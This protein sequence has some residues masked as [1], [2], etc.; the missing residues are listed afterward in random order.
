MDKTNISQEENGGKNALYGQRDTLTGFLCRDAMETEVDRLLAGKRPGLLLIMDID[1]FQ[2]INEEY[3]HMAGD[4]F[5]RKLPE[6]MGYYFFKKD[7]IGRIGG[8]E[9]SVFISGTEKKDFLYGKMGGM[10]ARIKQAAQKMGLEYLE[11]TIGAAVTENRD[12]F[13][14]LCKRASL[15]MRSGKAGQRKEVNFYHGALEHNDNE[16]EMGCLKAERFDDL[17]YVCRQLEGINS[18]G[19]D[20][21]QDYLNFLAVC[22]FLKNR[23]FRT[24]F[25]AQLVLISLSEQHGC[26]IGLRERDFLAD[27]LKKSIRC[28]LRSSD[29]FIQYSCCQFLAV[30]PD[31]APEHAALV[32]NRIKEAFRSRLPDRS[33]IIL[34]FS[35]HPL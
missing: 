17:K 28:A 19:M 11:V 27:Q 20:V 26:F 6:I 21:G 1:N 7:V 30:I 13:Q 5:L 25:C 4:M 29:I 33:D 34:V 18:C 16:A 35:F 24:G 22:R 23:F 14:S 9:F 8:D 2:H 32:E 12:T 31:A 10:Q 15:A 3:G